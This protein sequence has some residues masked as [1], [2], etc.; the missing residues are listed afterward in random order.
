MLDKLKY[1]LLIFLFCSTVSVSAKTDNDLT[2]WTYVHL[3]IPLGD[4]F[5]FRTTVSPRLKDNLDE[6][7]IVLSRNHL[8]YL[9]NRNF[10]FDLG[11]DFFQNF[12]NSNDYENRLWQQVTYRHQ[13]KQIEIAH[14]IRNEQRFFSD[15][16]MIERIRYMLRF[17]YPFGEKYRLKLADELFVNLNDNANRDFGPEQNRVYLGCERII[18]DKLSVEI[19]Y[20]LQHMLQDADQLNHV[21]VLH[22]NIGL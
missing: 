11:Y 13:F 3:T 20:Q 4:D 9:P 12:N 8:R 15:E 17:T 1:P 14:R 7:D 2:A 21:V 6:W 19:A 18:N 16:D 5:A 10:E 22:F